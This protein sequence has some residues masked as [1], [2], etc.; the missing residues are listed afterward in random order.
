MSPDK[1]TKETKKTT[2]TS[3]GSSKKLSQKAGGLMDYILPMK[4]AKL[5]VANK[6]KKLE[7]TFR[8]LKIAILDFE[9]YTNKKI[10]KHQLNLTNLTLLNKPSL[11]LTDFKTFESNRKSLENSRTKLL[12]N[13]YSDDII[14]LVKNLRKAELNY[15][16]RKVRYINIVNQLRAKFSS[17][18]EKYEGLISSKGVDDLS[19]FNKK[20]KGRMIQK[21]QENIEAAKE[22]KSIVEEERKSTESGI[23]K[24][25][26]KYLDETFKFYG[27][28]RYS[29]F[30]GDDTKN[31]KHDSKLTLD[32]W[33][34]DESEYILKI[35]G[36]LNK[37]I[38]ENC[39]NEGDIEYNSNSSGGGYIHQGGVTNNSSESIYNI[40]SPDNLELRKYSDNC[41]GNIHELHDIMISLFSLNALKITPLMNRDFGLYNMNNINMNS[42]SKFPV[43]VEKLIYAFGKNETKK[44]YSYAIYQIPGI[45]QKIDDKL[46]KFLKLNAKYLIIKPENNNEIVLNNSCF[47][48]IISESIYNT[49]D[50]FQAAIKY[51]IETI[52]KVKENVED[53][54]TNMEDGKYME[55]ALLVDLK[56]FL[57]MLW[58]DFIDIITKIG[59]A[60]YQ[61][62]SN[63]MD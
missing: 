4:R 27:I 9:D 7:G 20:F 19:G 8:K 44:V 45:I 29:Q 58:A 35:I 11:L 18:R 51:I 50:I 1:R 6:R 3:N 36:K 31:I 32:Q 17:V 48:G 40:Y 37:K 43:F 38:D 33:K 30:Y 46:K 13:M 26:E 15:N 21:T 39:R 63:E 16:I 34:I 22:L 57:K 14:K 61:E 56:I 25:M 47:R 52:A 5:K 59:K 24:D 54:L 53:L 55:N 23:I 42:A 10:I 49:V 41:K 60:V 28:D 2:K 12:K 62:S